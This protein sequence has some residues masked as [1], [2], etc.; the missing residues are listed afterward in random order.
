MMRIGLVA[1]LATP[2]APV[3][4]GSIESLVW[5]LARL[6]SDD[7]HAVT[8]FAAEGSD[9]SGEL[10]STL[11]AGYTGDT[12]ADWQTC[13]WINLI[14]AIRASARLD[15]L[16]SHAYLYGLPL[17]PLAHAPMVHTL[18]VQPDEPSRQLWRR[19]PDT[20][21]TALSRYQWS[22]F[23]ELRPAAIV[24][25]GID[26]REFTFQPTSSD[27]LCYLGR[28][29]EGKDPLL[30]IE[31]S[32]A[33]GMRLV[34]AGP[35]SKYFVERVAPL[36]DGRTIEY[37]GPVNGRDRI[38]LLGGARGLLYPVRAPEPFGLVMIEAMMCGVPVAA[39]R[40]GAVA[41]IVDEDVTG[42]TAA[43]RDEL[44]AAAERALTLSRA[45][46]RRRA[47]ERFSSARMARAYL[48]VYRR[49]A[50]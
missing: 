28:F 25:H 1:P 23:P 26:V 5:T 3:G 50:G 42:C 37:V 40:R 14:E 49:V 45:A 12:P 41:E 21:V 6:Y 19:Y 24:H 15:I 29:T 36:V 31:T 33:L 43:T 48:D 27:Y 18:H 10:V 44:P 46:V 16:H 30:A 11:P 35:Q 9:V 7:G 32:R 17:Q 34:M 39:M 22:G 4:A 20:H 2:V 38:N 47:E 8:V 13:E